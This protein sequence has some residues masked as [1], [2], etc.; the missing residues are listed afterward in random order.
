MMKKLTFFVLA[1]L[2]I[3]GC[4]K[5]T[6]SLRPADEPLKMTDLSIPDG[7]GWRTTKDVSCDFS[8]PNLTKVYVAT[9]PD[10]EPFAVFM[11]GNDAGP[12]HLEVPVPVNTLYVSYGTQS[13]VSAPEAVA[14]AQDR[15]VYAVPQNS[16]DYTGLEDGDRNST[17]GNVIYMPARSQGWGTLLFEDLWPSYGD[18]DFNDF[19]V[20]Y[21]VQLYMNNKN[22]VREMLIGIRV[23]AVGGSLPYDLYLQLLGVRGGEIDEIEYMG[24]AN[25]PD[26]R[27]RALN[28]ANYVHDPALLKFENIRSNPNKP[29]GAAYVNTEEGYEMAETELVEAVFM[30]TFRNSIDYND[31]AFRMF[32]FFIGRE[33]D[34]G[35][36]AEIHL[37]GYKPTA[38]GLSYYDRITAGH[39][40]ID[41]ASVPYRSNSGMT[42]A[43]NIPASI[44]HA[45]EKGSFLEAYPDFA[46]WA[47]S[48][49]QQA[50]DWY[51]HGD[52]SLLVG[53]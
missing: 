21:K 14:V 34:G 39:P 3:T 49:G 42:W 10:A 2:F 1:A 22:K 29:S 26:A 15:A 33:T 17:E 32:D 16:K 4:A 43:L 20:N 18:Y 45:Y 7:F 28:D 51:E 13:G 40:N 6:S 27:L 53:K 50:A 31:V 9:A 52:R 12:V 24:G 47:Q 25:A 5:D 23:E 35:E 46:K 8:S 19:V 48:G 30:V 41:G 36:R 38:D 37:D 11:A 44:R